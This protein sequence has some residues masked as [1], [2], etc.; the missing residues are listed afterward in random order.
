MARG[1]FA[2]AAGAAGHL[3]RAGGAGHRGPMSLDLDA[4]E[5]SFDA[6]VPRGPELMDRFYARLFDAAPAVA[7][8][9]MTTDL[10]R[11]KQKLLAALVILRRSL[12]DLD[13]VVPTL[14]KLG[15]RH[16]HYGA[17]PEHYPVVGAVLIQSMADVAGAG[18]RPE[19]ERA[20]K[21]A[22]AVVAGA[23]IAGAAEAGATA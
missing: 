20:W 21:S 6:V 11:Q 16:A 17:R 10:R 13:A 7:P 8:L 18:W 5:V 9:F 3:A 12:R 1:R 23:M 22:F 14:H 4:L 2:A 15:A 19:Y